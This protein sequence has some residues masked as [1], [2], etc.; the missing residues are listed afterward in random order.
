MVTPMPL[1]ADLPVTVILSDTPCPHV[2]YAAALPQLPP[3][4]PKW[5]TLCP[6][7]VPIS[8]S[9]SVLVEGDASSRRGPVSK[10]V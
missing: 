4:T 2:R 6:V 9:S 7:L 5:T 10:S 3:H 8:Q 1:T